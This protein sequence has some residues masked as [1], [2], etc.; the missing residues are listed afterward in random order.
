MQ[1]AILVYPGMTALDAIGPYEV[2]RALRGELCFVWKEIGPIV[3][4]S[5]VL[6]I[7]ATHRFDELPRPDLVLV[8]GSGTHTATTMIDPA[9]LSWLRAVHPHT[10]LTTSVCSGSL[11][12]AAAGLLEGRAATSHWAVLPLLEQFGVV[13]RANDRIVQDGK[14]RTAAGV[15]AGIDLALALVAE[16]KSESAARMA[17]LIIEYDPQP[18]FDCGHVSKVRP[19]LR[20]RARASMLWDALS[21]AELAALPQALLARWRE[22][23]CRRV[24]KGRV[25]KGERRWQREDALP[26]PAPRTALPPLRE[27]AQRDQTGESS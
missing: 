23:I 3:T 10:R 5:G 18:P 14:F 15:S 11:I 17:Q 7:G 20:E 12:L 22:V 8:P 13:P 24:R 6:T 25:G 4:D 26:P 2:L 1:I 9:V 27:N 16:L 21:Y 19:E